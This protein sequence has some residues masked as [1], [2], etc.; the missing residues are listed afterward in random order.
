MDF[1]SEEM[2]MNETQN[3]KAIDNPASSA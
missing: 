1:W 2:R 3:E